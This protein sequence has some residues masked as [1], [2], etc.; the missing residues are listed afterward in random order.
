MT[1]TTNELTSN[2]GLPEALKDGEPAG[3]QVDDKNNVFCR[4]TTE[5]SNTLWFALDVSL[6]DLA[7]VMAGALG[8]WDL[9]NAKHINL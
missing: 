6:K 8:V 4:H 1:M 2:Y 7:D 9:D 5:A 3:V